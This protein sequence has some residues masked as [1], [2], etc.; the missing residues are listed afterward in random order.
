[1]VETRFDGNRSA[2]ARAIGFSHA[3]ISRVV[4]GTKPGRRLLAA[5][6][7][8]LHVNPA[9]LAKGQGQ[10]FPEEAA[11][12]PGIPVTNILLPGPP[13]AH[14]AMLTGWLTVPEVVESSTA[15]WLVLKSS[16][17]IVRRPSSGF[18][19]GDQLLMETDPFK[20]P[21]E[22]D[23][24][25][26]LCVV[27]GEGGADLRL[28]AVSYYAASMDSGP[29]RLEADYYDA[30]PPEAADQSVVENVYRHHPDGVVEHFQRHHTHVPGWTLRPV[31]E[32]DLSQIRYTD[33]VAVW[34]KILRREG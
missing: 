5:V 12:G 20:F 33:V 8:H 29:A 9:W 1:L 24:R 15:F 11:G 34:L 16:Q 3:M 14:Q 4:A 32:P 13:A 18:R 7:N 26:D 2:L 19:T 27:R 17:P 6:A 21:R 28:A 30:A 22:A 23:M 10:P 25:D 31:L